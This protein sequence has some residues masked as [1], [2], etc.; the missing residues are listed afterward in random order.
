MGSSDCISAEIISCQGLVSEFHK[1]V[2]SRVGLEDAR[3]F[4][5]APKDPNTASLLMHDSAVPYV[6]LT[7]CQHHYSCRARLVFGVIGARTAPRLSALRKRACVSSF[8]NP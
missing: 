7:L 5:R 6:F 4:D 8:T 1:G 2:H 3:I